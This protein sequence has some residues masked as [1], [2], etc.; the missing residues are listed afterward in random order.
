MSVLSLGERMWVQRNDGPPFASQLLD[1]GDTGSQLIGVEDETTDWPPGR[2]TVVTLVWHSERGRHEQR[3]AFLGHGGTAAP[4]WW[5]LPRD[6][7]ALV[8]RRY[9]ARAPRLTDVEIACRGGLLIDATALDL[10]E[11]GMRCLL[12]YGVQ[13]L[14]QEQLTVSFRCEDARVTVPGWIIRTNRRADDRL[15]IALQMQPEPA[16]AERIWRLVL[17]WQRQSRERGL[18]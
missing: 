2:D 13:L 7:V 12:P 11:G 16:D 15:E 4:S 1:V 6:D 14:P 18:L 3:A 10:S 5:V 9:H 8:Q 17:R